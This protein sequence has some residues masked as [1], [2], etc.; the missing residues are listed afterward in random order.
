MISFKTDGYVLFIYCMFT[1][2]SLTKDSVYVSSIGQGR[3]KR[4]ISFSV[5]AVNSGGE[6]YNMLRKAQERGIFNAKET[7]L[8]RRFIL[9]EGMGI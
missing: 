3:Q 4:E 1:I 5:Q 8:L 6:I 7:Q 2:Y 9:S